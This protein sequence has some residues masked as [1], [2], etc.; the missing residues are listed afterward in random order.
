MRGLPQMLQILSQ[1]EKGE[2]F[3]KM[4]EKQWKEEKEKV[5]EREGAE[6]GILNDINKIIV[7]KLLLKFVFIIILDHTDWFQNKTKWNWKQVVKRQHT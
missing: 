5:L 7:I 1:A 2:L 4:K 6:G 3:C